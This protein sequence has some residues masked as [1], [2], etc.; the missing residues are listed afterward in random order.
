[1]DDDDDDDDDENDIW[2]RMES[3]VP[4]GVV[5]IIFFGYISMGAFMFHRFEDWPMI[6]SLY[7]CY[8]TLATVGFGDYVCQYRRYLLQV[9]YSNCFPR[10]RA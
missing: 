5:M 8:V 3:G 10:Y 2:A 7:F 1:M 4:F 9:F 6:Q